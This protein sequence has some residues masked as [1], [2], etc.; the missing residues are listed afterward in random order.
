M[1]NE[2]AAGGSPSPELTSELSRLMQLAEA[3]ADD[4]PAFQQAVATLREAK[5]K[6]DDGDETGAQ[7]QLDQI[8]DWVKENLLGSGIADTVGALASSVTAGV[9][10]LFGGGDDAE[11]DSGGEA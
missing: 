2:H 3:H 5:Q 10:N 11:K 1:S 9:S 6:A 8:W 4:S 7:A